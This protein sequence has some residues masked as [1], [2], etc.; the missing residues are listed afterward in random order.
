MIAFMGFWSQI[1]QPVTNNL[2]T[3]SRTLIFS[4]LSMTHL[5]EPLSCLTLRSFHLFLNICLCLPQNYKANGLLRPIRLAQDRFSF[6]GNQSTLLS[7][8]NPSCNFPQQAILR[9]DFF[10]L[11]QLEIGYCRT[12]RRIARIA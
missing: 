6:L 3:S 2:G 9:M 7:P 4:M 5:P 10:F 1:S 12:S 8:Q 11:Q